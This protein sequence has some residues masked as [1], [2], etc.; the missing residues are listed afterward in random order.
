MIQWN[1]W[2][3]MN[4]KIP[5]YVVYLFVLITN[6]AIGQTYKV[7]SWTLKLW[8]VDNTCNVSNSFSRTSRD[9][10]LLFPSF[11]SLIALL[12]QKLKYVRMME[13]GK[14]LLFVP[15]KKIMLVHTRM[16]F[17]GL[18]QFDKIVSRNVPSRM[19]L[20]GH[21]YKCEKVKSNVM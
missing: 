14:Y 8:L 6:S 18:V 15:W 4:I 2:N 11:S 20:E 13:K 12:E 21:G 1:Y 5:V 19:Q 9:S 17:N 7:E 10:P 16:Y 3:K